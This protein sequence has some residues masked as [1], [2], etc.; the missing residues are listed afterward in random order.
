MLEVASRL[1]ALLARAATAG[2]AAATASRTFSSA[3]NHGSSE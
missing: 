2:N 3:V 1:G